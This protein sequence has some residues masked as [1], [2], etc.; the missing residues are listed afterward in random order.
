MQKN[1]YA[2]IM[3]GGPGKRFWP[4]SRPECPKP[5]LRLWGEK[6]LLQTCCARLK[7]VV[8]A[9]NIIVI[10]AEKNRGLIG[11]Q[12]PDIAPDN[13]I[14]EAEGRDS[15]ACIALGAALVA[16][17]NPEAELLVVPADQVIEPV[18]AFAGD[19]RALAAAVAAERC[20]GTIG[21]PPVEPATRFGYI[22]A[23]ASSGTFRG[24]EVFSVSK[25]REKPGPEQARAYL[26]SGDYL[27]NAGIFLAPAG[28]FK[29]EIRRCEPAFD[30][31][32][33]Q[34]GTLL[35]QGTDPSAMTARL[36]P[37]VPKLS[38]DY[39]VIEKLAKVVTLKAS[40]Q[41]DDVGDWAALTRYVPEDAEGNVVRGRCVSRDAARNIICVE[42]LQVAA[43]GVEDLVIAQAGASI[44]V[45][46][47]D[48]LSELKELVNRIE[49]QQA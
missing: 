30:P 40:F 36:Y 1:L 35:E 46:R 10:A 16:H 8:P 37:L 47:R 25:F 14:G 20:I 48:R 45:A 43:L 3:A 18:E 17:R 4:L 22:Q 49:E 33:S 27:W 31:F 5:F 34:C 19:V 42:D 7:A 32:F 41:W 29:S 38:I 9:E 28:V 12:L 26:A 15:A 6:S 39:A 13:I 24:K 21:I 11:A 44:L 2:V 23:G